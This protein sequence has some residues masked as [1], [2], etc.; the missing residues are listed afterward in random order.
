[1]NLPH[2]LARYAGLG[3]VA[4]LTA[5]LAQVGPADAAAGSQPSA[6]VVDH[7]LRIIGTAGEDRITVAFSADGASA[8]VAFADGSPAT[9]FNRSDFANVAVF[10]R[11]GDDQFHAVSGGAGD[12]R[13]GVY[14]GSGDD[15]IVGG[16]GDDVLAG[17]D[18]NDELRGGPGADVLYGDRGEDVIDGGIGADTEFLGSGADAAL[19]VPGE[20]SDIVHGGRGA[21][22]FAFTGGASADSMTLNATGQ[23]SVFLREPGS[24]RMDLDSVE[25]LALK[26]LGGADRLTVN[27][28]DAPESVDV[29]NDAGH[30][31]VTGVTPRVTILGSEQVDGLQLN[32]LGG[33]DRVQLHAG[34]S[35]LITASVDLGTGQ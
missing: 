29:R 7:T 30:V 33:H 24:I 16:S 17:A 23:Q 14:G 9:G 1:M 11:S 25:V 4:V 19:W 5:A 28:T 26:P 27:G 21:D 32:T 35:D 12:P 8:A 15:V 10:L 20:G 13:I 22:T 3:A 2:N 18:G 31:V 6:R 34:V